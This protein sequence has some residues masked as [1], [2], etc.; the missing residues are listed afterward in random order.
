MEWAATLPWNRWQLSRGL[1]G[2]F[3]VEYAIASPAQSPDEAHARA[4][5]F[6][7]RGKTPRSADS[8]AVLVGSIAKLGHELLSPLGK[9]AVFVHPTPDQPAEYLVDDLHCFGP[10]G[11]SGELIGKRVGSDWLQ[12]VEPQD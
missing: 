12:M 10:N 5:K 8:N 4:T 3:H 6:P 11:M 1:G 2:N 7:A 9:Q